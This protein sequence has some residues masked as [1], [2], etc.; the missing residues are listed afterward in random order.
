M[1]TASSR[2]EAIGAELLPE[3]SV[4]PQEVMAWQHSARGGVLQG[5][6]LCSTSWEPA[7]T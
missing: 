6:W 4:L 1:T 3:K 2:W 7:V 5:A